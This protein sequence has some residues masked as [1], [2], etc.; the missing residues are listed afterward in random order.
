[1]IYATVNEPA[2]AAALECV[3]ARVTESAGETDGKNPVSS[4]ALLR[5]ADVMVAPGH[6][7]V[8]N[9]IRVVTDGVRQRPCYSEEK[10]R[11]AW[12]DCVR[13]EA[14]SARVG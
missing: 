6:D 10:L 4:S 11:S 13:F 2:L 1:M 3:I 5:R 12:R 7:S 9:L 8:I 14:I